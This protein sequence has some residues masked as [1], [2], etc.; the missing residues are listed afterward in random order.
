[1]LQAL[2]VPH[3]IFESAGRRGYPPAWLVVLALPPV[4][5]AAV[6][7]VCFNEIAYTARGLFKYMFIY[8]FIYLFECYSIPPGAASGIQRCC[9]AS[10]F[11][12]R[13]P[14]AAEAH[15]G[16]TVRFRTVGSRRL[17]TA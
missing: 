12:L 3:D 13:V 6:S 2:P 8:V 9:L 16:R 4:C 5:S 15:V 7:A 14:G 1:M 17:F 11:R 10:T